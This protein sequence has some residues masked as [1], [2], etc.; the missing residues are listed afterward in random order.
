MRGR[1]GGATICHSHLCGWLSHP[2]P[3][4]HADV[5]PH[6][7]ST[8]QGGCWSQNREGQSWGWHLPFLGGQDQHLPAA[9]ETL[10][11]ILGCW[12]KPRLRC[13]GPFLDQ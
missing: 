6:G 13:R 11:S 1:C 7:T 8:Y 9:M 2:V 12:T 5:P 10:P 4:P 3:M